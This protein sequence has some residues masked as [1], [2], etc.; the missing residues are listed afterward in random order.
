MSEI[1]VV[2]AA[3]GAS[4]IL[5]TERNLNPSLAWLRSIGLQTPDFPARRYSQRVG[6]VEYA[7]TRN[8]DMADELQEGAAFGLMGADGFGE[9][10]PAR[11]LRF[12]AV[13]RLAC[14]FGLFFPE[15][16]A[17]D[18][19]EAISVATS[20]PCALTEFVGRRG[21]RLASILLKQGK[22]ERCPASG[23]TQ[24]GFDIVETG[25]TL[26]NNGLRLVVRDAPLMLGGVWREV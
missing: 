1:D 10:S 20:N 4:A 2:E 15:E 7:I 24:A 5:M 22:I 25:S 3:R 14:R 17:W 11:A 6:G 16:A 18:G 13:S 19:R 9:L 21:I 26:R 8:S 12:E 23:Q